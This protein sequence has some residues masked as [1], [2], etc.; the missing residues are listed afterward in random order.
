MSILG[1][2]A[3]IGLADKAPA[4]SSYL[5]PTA[6]STGYGS[7]T[8]GAQPSYGGEDYAAYDDYD[9]NAQA[10][11]GDQVRRSTLYLLNPQIRKIL[12]IN[13]QLSI[14]DGPIF[15]HMSSL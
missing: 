15:N 10:S 2:G 4:G 3:S 13:R 1:I 11:Y 8:G 7:P 9:Q 6:A 14:N 5:P 12:H